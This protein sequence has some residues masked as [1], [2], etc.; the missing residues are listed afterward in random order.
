MF[1]YG[2]DYPTDEELFNYTLSSTAD[3]VTNMTSDN[4]TLPTLQQVHRRAVQRHTCRASPR[5]HRCP[6]H[7]TH[8]TRV[9]ACWRAELL[10][11]A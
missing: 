9:H 2:C 7:G 5:T 11:D 1:A 8:R 3:E 4:F 6:R 10:Y